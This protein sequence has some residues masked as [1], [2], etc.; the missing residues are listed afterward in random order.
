ME[1]KKIV[2]SY[3]GGLD[4]SVM[5]TWLKENYKGAEII[6]VTGDVGQGESELE[7]LEEKALK[8][9]ASKVYILDLKEELVN[10]Y[11]IPAIKAGA[12]YENSYLLGTTFSRPL[13]AKKLVEIANKEGAT[14]ICHGA[15]G[16]GNDQVRFELGIKNFAPDIEVIVPWRTWELKTREKEIEY[17]KAHNI[18]L[19]INKE[20][21]YSKD[22]NLWHLSH[23][24]LDLEDIENEP[25][26]EKILEM[27]VS[28]KQAPDKEEELTITFEKGVPTSINGIKMSVLDI[29]LK[30]NE[31]GGRNGIGIVDMV[32]NRLVGMKSRGVYETPGGTIIYKA[33]ELLETI[34]LDKDTMHYKQGV[35]NK[36][37]ELLYN[38]CWFTPLRE[39]LSAFI[40]KTQENVTGEVKLKLYK[41]NIINAGISSPHSLYSKQI[42]SFDE[43]DEYSHEDS[44]GFINLYGLPTKVRAKKMLKLKK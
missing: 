29:I 3:S 32:E 2:L 21:N 17:A 25:Q 36:F 30:L 8:T 28:P 22:K 43:E 39:A 12:K 18:P 7:G 10:E 31:I 34:C 33:H 35:S 9:G 15:T 20:T 4:T 40:E 6:A 1:H 27:S 26:Y 24:G 38:A 11:I 14:A 41:G 37:G 19:T 23:E 5:I 44:Q 13:I 16:K 42:A